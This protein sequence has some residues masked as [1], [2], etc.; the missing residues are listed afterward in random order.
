MDR[1]TSRQ[2]QQL[3]STV[4][5]CAHIQRGV[6]DGGPHARPSC[7]VY[8]VRQRLALEDIAQEGII[9]DVSAVNRELVAVIR[10]LQ[11]GEV[12]VLKPHVVIVIHF[13]NHHYSITPSVSLSTYHHKPQ[14][15]VTSHQ[16]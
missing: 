7:Q 6:M 16:N 10:A 8:D 11:Y 14:H 4:H 9:T 15:Q 2:I 12:V 1:V 13:I 5:I 3:A